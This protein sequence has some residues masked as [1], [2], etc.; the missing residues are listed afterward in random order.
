MFLPSCVPEVEKSLSIIASGGFCSSG[1]VAAQTRFGTINVP[2]AP[3][4]GKASLKFSV[5]LRSLSADTENSILIFLSIT[6]SPVILTNA[7][8]SIDAACI[9][10]AVPAVVSTVISGA[11]SVPKGNETLT[12]FDDSVILSAFPSI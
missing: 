12:S 4:A 9:T 6:P 2:F 5:M 3:S 10:C 11:F 7:L 1:T 8:S